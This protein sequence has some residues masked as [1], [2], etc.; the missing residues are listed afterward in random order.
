[1]QSTNVAE[2]LNRILADRL[3]TIRGDLQSIRADLAKYTAEHSM[4]VDWGIEK[5]M[6]RLI[7]CLY[8]L[9]ATQKSGLFPTDTGT[10]ENAVTTVAMAAEACDPEEAQ[11]WDEA[12]GMIEKI[13]N[14]TEGAVLAVNLAITEATA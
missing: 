12:L 5:T 13:I 9:R 7:G 3:D 10:F 11:D 4:D 1:M 6:Y 2:R 8:T 14:L